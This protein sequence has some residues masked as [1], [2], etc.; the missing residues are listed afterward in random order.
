MEVVFYRRKTNRRLFSFGDDIRK[1]PVCGKELQFRQAEAVKSLSCR[2]KDVESEDVITDKAYFI[3]DDD[4]FFTREFVKKALSAIKK[5]KTPTQFG[6]AENR[7]NQRWVLPHSADDSENLKFSFFFR[8]SDSSASRFYEIGQHLIDDG[9]YIPDQIVQGGHYYVGRSDCF[10]SRIASPFHLLQ[11]NLAFNLIRTIEPQKNYPQWLVDKIAP[12]GSWLYNRALKKLNRIGKK[13]KIHPTAVIEASVIGDNVTIGAFAVVRFSHIGN[14]CV[15]SD[16]VT[17][18]NS[19]LGQNNYIA[20]SNYLGFNLLFDNVFLIHGPYQFSVF[21]NHSAAFAVIN[22]DIRLDRQNIRIP[23]DAG[24]LNSNQ[25]LL[26][27]AYG[28]HSK[29]GGGN[30]IAAGRIVPNHHT[31]NPPDNIIMKFDN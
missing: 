4:L 24:V 13:C 2:M 26:G 6:L 19:V 15:I 14:G 21:G 16:Q 11:V 27:I 9:F 25:P 3:F 12:E 23:T 18:I 29:T 10:I 5:D 17:V 7:F 8:N 22:C 1:V 30:I 20:N 31:I 28:H